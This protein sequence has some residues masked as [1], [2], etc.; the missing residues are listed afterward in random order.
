MASDRDLLGHNKALV[1]EEHD[2]RAR[3]TEAQISGD[4][5][6][7]RL[8][9]VEVELD[10][11]GKWCSPNRVPPGRANTMCRKGPVSSSRTGPEPSNRWYQGTLTDKPETRVHKRA[12]STT[13]C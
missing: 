3:R 9:E 8:N 6:H 1:E 12:Q 4:E 10:R 5:E 11:S 13:S 7:R 2:L